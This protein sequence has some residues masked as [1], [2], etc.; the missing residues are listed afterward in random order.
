MMDSEPRSATLL[1][2]VIV[3][4]TFAIHNETGAMSP[5]DHLPFSSESTGSGCLEKDRSPE[6]WPWAEPL[7]STE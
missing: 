5:L 1:W 7:G 6:A 3:P 2:L 4:A